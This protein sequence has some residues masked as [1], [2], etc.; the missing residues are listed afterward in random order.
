MEDKQASLS[1]A[2]VTSDSSSDVNLAS[3]AFAHG[4]TVKIRY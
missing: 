1:Y 3:S 4:D 2:T